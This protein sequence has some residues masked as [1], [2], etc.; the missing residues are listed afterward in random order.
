MARGIDD[1]HAALAEAALDLIVGADPGAGIEVL[2]VEPGLAL[3]GDP[4]E[5]ARLRI[6]PDTDGDDRLSQRRIAIGRADLDHARDGLVKAERD[7][8]RR[9]ADAPHEPAGG[10]QM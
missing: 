2:G 4:R 7:L 10:D 3:G 1:G 9:V 8:P 6:A 5:G